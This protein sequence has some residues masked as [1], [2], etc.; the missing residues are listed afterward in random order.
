ME[1]NKKN[2]KP[3]LIINIDENTTPSY[4]YVE[5]A[6][7]KYNKLFNAT[8][9]MIIE[10]DNIDNYFR[11][12]DAIVSETYAS[13]N[14]LSIEDEDSEIYAKQSHKKSW[15]KRVFNKIFKKNK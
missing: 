10:L 3:E 13:I 12:L 6:K 1:K 2:I 4:I 8:E 14:N 9:R 15:V 5:I 11:K 7:Y